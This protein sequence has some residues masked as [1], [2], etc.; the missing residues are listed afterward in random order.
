DGFSAHHRAV[1]RIFAVILEVPAIPHVARKIDPA[2][3][4]DVK[5]TN[6]RLA[7][8]RGAAFPRELWVEARS[9]DN[10]CRERRGSLV[11]RSITGIGD[12]HAGVARLQRR[13]TESRDAPCITCAVTLDVRGN[14]LISRVANRGNRSHE[15][16]DQ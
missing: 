14:T 2:G 12:S 8:D 4:H 1:K 15:T 16:R 9:H 3:E 13:D 5:T 10:G 7:A 6:S 11:V